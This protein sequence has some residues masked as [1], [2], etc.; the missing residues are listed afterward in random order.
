MSSSGWGG[1][2]DWEIPIF[3]IR[4][5]SHGSAYEVPVS[6][7]NHLIFGHFG[8]GRSGTGQIRGYGRV[9]PTPTCIQAFYNF[10]KHKHTGIS[11]HANL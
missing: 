1:L 2:L 4:P 5:V 10:E 7:K 6:C 11:K 8:A 9:L 3:A